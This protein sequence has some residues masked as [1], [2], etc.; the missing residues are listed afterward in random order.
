MRSLTEATLYPGVCLLEPTN[1]SVGRGT[2]TPFELV[3]APWI[4]GRRLAEA[5]NRA[6]LPGVRFVPVRFTPRA[7]VHKDAECGGVNIIV[8]DRARFEPVL[9][10]LEMAA[11]IRKLFGT[12]FNSDRFLRLLVSQKVFDAF[13]QGADGRTMRLTYEGDLDG[14]RAVRRKYLLY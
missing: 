2:D 12:A 1:V 6:G 13:R 14:F 11:Q 4:D 3:G 7:S 5:L 8:T 10:G 9:T